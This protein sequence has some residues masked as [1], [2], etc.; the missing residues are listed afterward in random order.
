M[1]EGLPPLERY[2][3]PIFV[4][5][6]LAI[7]GGAAMLIFHRPPPVTIE[8]VPRPPTATPAP[9]DT[10]GP[11]RV[12]VSG[13]VSSPGIYELPWG[14]IARDAIEAA[15]GATE[16]AD[17]DRVNL[18]QPLRDG[19]QIYVPP[20]SD[21]PVETATPAWPLNINTATAEELEM[22]PHIGP[23][24]A[25]RIVEFREANGPFESVEEL[26]E[27]PGIGPAILEELE[28]LITVE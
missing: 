28:G 24:L 3:N 2:K 21:E 4:L 5:L 20:R 26:D 7:V 19:I 27:V 1:S 8:I 15:G 23:T 16:G 10:P 18:A 17:L 13:E 22:L 6:I 12:Y 11:V 25:Q 14:S 9:T